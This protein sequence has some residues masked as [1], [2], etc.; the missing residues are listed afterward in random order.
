MKYSTRH[1]DESIYIEVAKNY[2]ALRDEWDKK[3]ASEK[4]LELCMCVAERRRNLH[5]S[6]QSFCAIRA[7]SRLDAFDMRPSCISET[8]RRLEMIRWKYGKLDPDAEIVNGLSVV[9]PI[10]GIWDLAKDDT[11]QSLLATINDCLYQKLFTKAKLIESI[12]K[13]RKRH[14]RKK[15]EKIVGLATEKCESALET[16]AW[17]LINNGGFV[18]PK[19]QLE[20][21]D[22]Q[23]FIGR[24]DMCWEIGLRKIILEVDG[25]GKYK[26]RNVLIAEKNREDKLRELGFE[27]IRA[28]W[29]DAK[30]GNLVRKLND[31][32]I[33][34]RRSYKRGII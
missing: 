27:V 2:F 30:S 14:G 16:L 8:T 34:R 10:R 28:T 24:V 4:H 23:Q 6:G 15:L 33:P 7:I 12:E 25:V 31:Q 20:I 26:D 32:G 5:F 11:C 18:F 22:K 19:Q 13:N 29:K 21:Y 9:S 3:H 1:L 17:I